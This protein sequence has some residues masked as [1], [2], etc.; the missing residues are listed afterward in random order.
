MAAPKDN[1]FKTE[2]EQA[3]LNSYIQQPGVILNPTLTPQLQKF[4]QEV[5]KT[6]IK[7]VVTPA[8]TYTG[9]FP[10][11]LSPFGYTTSI[12]VHNL[13]YIPRVNPIERF[14]VVSGKFKVPLEAI[15]K[16]DEIT[17]NHIAVQGTVGDTIRI[18]LW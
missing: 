17:S 6:V 12:I 3:I 9:P 1:V 10:P 13:G 8:F 5:H 4:C 11:G 2:L 18:I 14:E 15:L 7:Y 16:I